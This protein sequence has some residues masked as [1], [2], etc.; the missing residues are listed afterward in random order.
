M[1]YGMVTRDNHKDP[2]LIMNISDQ[3]HDGLNK[4]PY[5]L[6]SCVFYCILIGDGRV[7][8]LGIIF[9]VVV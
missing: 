8:Y 6:F 7:A 4:P 2:Y 9:G 5:R 3:S 1:K